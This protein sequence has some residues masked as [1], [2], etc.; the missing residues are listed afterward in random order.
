MTRWVPA[1]CLLTSACGAADALEARRIA[2]EGNAAYR[3]GDYAVAIDRY[4]RAI[5]LDPE[6]PNV[7]LNLGYALFSA[8]NPDSGAELDKQRA[9]EAVAAFEHHLVQVPT[10]EKARTYRIKMLLRAAP[11]DPALADKAYASF[12]ELLSRNPDDVEVKQYLVSLFIETKAYRKAVTYYADKLDAATMKI[13]AVIADKSGEI[14]EAIGWYRKRAEAAANN[15]EKAPLFYELGTYVWNLLHY[16]PD[17]T[18]AVEGI[19]FADLGIEATKRAMA[20]QPDYAEAMVYG[21]LLYLER[22]N[23]EPS[24][25]GRD[26]DLRL[27]YDLRT[28]AGKLFAA[29]KGAEKVP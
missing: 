10:D 29:R 28:A 27:A 17:K 6:T 9:T 20:L 26:I 12:V 21:N 4:K 7:H 8:Y 13:L 2:R 5:A 11:Y 3:D 16:S 22:A 23:R 1:L 15:G 19:R 25:Q 18:K 14:D 24:E